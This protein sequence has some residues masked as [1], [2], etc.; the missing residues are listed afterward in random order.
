MDDTEMLPARPAADWTH[1]R[2][3]QPVTVAENGHPARTGTIDAVTT[4]ASILWVRLPGI[5]PR[6]MFLHTDPVDI[7]SAH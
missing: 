5:A 2:P 6:R 1:L 3:G 4:D 7:R